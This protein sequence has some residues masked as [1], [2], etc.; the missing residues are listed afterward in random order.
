MYILFGINI[1]RL[2]IFFY[3]LIFISVFVFIDLIYFYIFIFFI[4][5]RKLLG[6]CYGERVGDDGVWGENLDCLGWFW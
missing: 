4:I 6:K 3:G 2:I 1:E 5:D